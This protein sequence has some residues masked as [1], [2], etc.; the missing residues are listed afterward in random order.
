MDNSQRQCRND[1]ISDMQIKYCTA[2]DTF[3]FALNIFVIA[4]NTELKDSNI[5]FSRFKLSD[6]CTITLYIESCKEQ[7][8]TILF[9]SF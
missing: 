4:I 5:C 7:L 3:M 8:S 6:W 1:I 2:V 9:L